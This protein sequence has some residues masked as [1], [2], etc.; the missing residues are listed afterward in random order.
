MRTLNSRGV[1]VIK[2]VFI[3]ESDGKNSVESS[4]A[5]IQVQLKKDFMIMQANTAIS[6]HAVVI[7]KKYTLLTD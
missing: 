5:S 2:G 3:T 7:H 1:P 4:Y 6:P